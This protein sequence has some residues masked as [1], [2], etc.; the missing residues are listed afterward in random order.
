MT[1]QSTP[2]YEVVHY[3][4]AVIVSGV[5]K[6]EATKMAREMSKGRPGSIIARPLKRVAA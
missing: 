1:R 6:T 3:M 2:K 4:G 5:S